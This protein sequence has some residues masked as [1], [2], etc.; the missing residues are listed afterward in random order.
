MSP[1]IRASSLTTCS[2]C[3]TPSE[4]SRAAL[5]TPAMLLEIYSTPC[6]ASATLR[7][8]SLVVAVC[9]STAAAMVFW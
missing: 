9:S 3:T 7:D 1:D 2:A 5:A 8:I 6:E 4:V